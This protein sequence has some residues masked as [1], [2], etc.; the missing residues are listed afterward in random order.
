MD[1]SMERACKDVYKGVARAK[2]TRRRLMQTAAASTA[3]FAATWKPEEVR[4]DVN[5]TVNVYAASGLRWDG[6]MRAAYPIFKEYFPNITVN[7]TSEPI[8]DTYQKISVMMNSK[9]DS[10]NV[11]Y[12]DFGQWPQMHSIGALTPLQQYADQDTEWFD[13]YL[14]DVPESITKLYRFPQVPSGDLYGLC[15]DGNAM[16]AAYRK[17]AFDKAGI[18]FPMTWEGWIEAA[19]ELNDPDREVYA[20]CAAMARGFWFG[21]EFWGAHASFGGEWF[22]RMEDGYWNPTFNTEAG[23]QALLALNELNKYAHPI[24]ANGGEDEVNT[25]F[26]NGSALFGPLTWGTANLN[27]PDFSHFPD[28][29]HW[30]VPPRGS[31][32]EGSHRPLMGGLGQFVPPWSPDHQAAWEW[33]KWIN[34]GDKTDPRIGE[35]MVKAGSQPSRISL[36]SKYGAERNFFNGL[37]KAFPTAIPFVMLIPEANSLVQMIG[38]EGAD[39]INGDIDIEDALKAMDK[40]ARRIMEDSGYYG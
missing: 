9:V 8:G 35:V 33:I 2:V 7:F 25:A 18:E 3:A 23:Y 24:T 16:L 5:G 19:K 20:Y 38:E 28:E 6:S 21:F 14:S 40:R 30:D 37:S 29:F 15:P 11:I 26:A 34:S 32:A 36:L 31:N 13:D 4:A 1:D 39:Y 10:F 12:T 27:N 17:D 22:D